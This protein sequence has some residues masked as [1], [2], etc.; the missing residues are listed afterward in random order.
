M[1]A[2]PHRPEVDNVAYKIEMLTFVFA[3]KVKKSVSLAATGTE[4]NVGKEY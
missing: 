4:M 1:D 3:Q 2:S